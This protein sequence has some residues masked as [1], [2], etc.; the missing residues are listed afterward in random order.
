MNITQY[1]VDLTAQMSHISPSSIPSTLWDYY[2]R[3]LW[4]YNPDSIVAR[5]AYTFRILAL[6]LIMPAVILI[7]LVESFF[8]KFQIP[9]IH[10]L[11]RTYPHTS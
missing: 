11:E 2:V 9:L 7:L 5:I 10:F 3:Y 8:F 1:A 6:L 4:Y